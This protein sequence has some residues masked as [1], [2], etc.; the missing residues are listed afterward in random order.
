MS[1]HPH[2]GLGAAEG[3]EGATHFE[4]LAALD[5]RHAQRVL[6]AVLGV[7]DLAVAPDLFAFGFL[8]AADDLQAVHGLALA[9]V[10]AFLAHGARL[11]ILG[12]AL[13]D[14]AAE[15]AAL[16]DDADLGPG[17]ARLV[18]DV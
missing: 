4:A 10:A 8:R 14:L 17:L 9:V 11:G 3:T 16:V 5:W 6:A 13:D 1:L 15:H 18:V 2:P 12:Q 7:E